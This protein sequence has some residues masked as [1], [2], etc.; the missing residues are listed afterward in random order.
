MPDSFISD[1]GFDVTPA[2]LDYIAPLV[3]AMP[4]YSAL[5][6]NRATL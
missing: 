3:G 2:F 6:A 1:D 4:K 5:S